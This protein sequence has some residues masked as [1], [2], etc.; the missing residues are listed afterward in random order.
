MRSIVNFP[1]RRE[2]ATVT[3]VPGSDLPAVLR[4]ILLAMFSNV[5]RPSSF[6]VAIHCKG[7]SGSGEI[8]GVTGDRFPF[9]ERGARDVVP[10]EIGKRESNQW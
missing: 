4:D 6:W 1:E 7:G 3:L 9:V 8:E 5:Q 2:S 10:I